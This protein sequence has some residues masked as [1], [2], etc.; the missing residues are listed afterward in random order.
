MIP[1]TFVKCGDVHEQRY[2]I[3]EVDL[4]SLYHARLEL[5]DSFF[6]SNTNGFGQ[7]LKGGR[8]PYFADRAKEVEAELIRRN[9]PTALPWIERKK[10]GEVNFT[11]A[12]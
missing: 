5:W 10:L 7:A 11:R 1:A 4:A 9:E 12:F 3:D 6:H 8:D 2:P